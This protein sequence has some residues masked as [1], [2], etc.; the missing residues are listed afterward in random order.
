MTQSIEKIRLI[1]DDLTFTKE[2]L[3][4]STAISLVMLG[5]LFGVLILGIHIFKVG[6]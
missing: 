4:I 2:E 6:F 1:N 3:C 5:F